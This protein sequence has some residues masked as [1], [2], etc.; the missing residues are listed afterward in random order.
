MSD[1]QIESHPFGGSVSFPLFCSCFEEV[2]LGRNKR[3]ICDNSGCADEGGLA[4]T[5]ELQGEWGWGAEDALV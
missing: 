2:V 3:L 5:D 4:A 1:G